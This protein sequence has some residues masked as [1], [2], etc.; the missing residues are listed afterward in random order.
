MN[1]VGTNGEML[2]SFPRESLPLRVN[3]IRVN[4]VLTSGLNAYILLKMSKLRGRGRETDE[5]AGANR[6]KPDSPPRSPYSFSPFPF[7]FGF[8]GF[9]EERYSFRSR[10]FYCQRQAPHFSFDEERFLFRSK[11][12]YCQRQPPHFGFDEER[13]SFRSKLFYYSIQP[14]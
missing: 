1:I 9:D 8:E 13:Y 14:S 7:R 2:H 5:S 4:Y 3:Q 11:L 6:Q 10:L 12:F